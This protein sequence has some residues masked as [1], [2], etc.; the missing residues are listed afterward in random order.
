MFRWLI[1]DSIYLVINAVDFQPKGLLFLNWVWRAKP[2]RKISF[3]PPRTCRHRIDL[4]R[5][6]QSPYPC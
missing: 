4:K 3:F 6:Q 5:R 1:H 2:A